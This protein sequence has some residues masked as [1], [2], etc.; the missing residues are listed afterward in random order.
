MIT[1]LPVLGEL[2]VVTTEVLNNFV[3]FGFGDNVSDMLIDVF[4]ENGKSQLFVGEIESSE[5]V[6]LSQK[7]FLSNSFN[8][9]NSV[10]C[11]RYSVSLFIQCN[12]FLS[13]RNKPKPISFAVA[14]I[15][16]GPGLKCLDR[17]LDGRRFE[18]TSYLNIITHL[19]EFCKCSSK[20]MA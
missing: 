6:G 18:Q 4:L 20:R 19:N 8:G 17:A 3:S 2:L 9:S 16:V 1:S 15:F 11:V 14:V 10:V 5:F 7:F 13:W 12:D